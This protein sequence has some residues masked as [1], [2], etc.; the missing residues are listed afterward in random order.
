LKIIH[1]DG[2]RMCDSEK[3]VLVIALGDHPLVNSLVAPADLGREDPVFPLDVHQCLDCGLVQL[4]DIIDSH[5]IYKNVDYLFFSSDMPTLPT[6]FSEYAEDIRRRFL[7][8]GG[9]ALEIGSNDGVL[10]NHLR[11]YARVL[12]VDPSTNV[13]LRALKRGIP[14]I[15]LFFG[16]DI[17]GKIWREWGSAD[18]IMGNNCIAHLNDLHDLMRGVDGLLADSGVFV[19]EANYWGGMVKNANFSLIYH[20]HYSFFSLKVWEEFAPK[21]G[22][23][24]FDAWVTP[25]QGG[26]LRLFMSKDNRPETARLQ[27]LRREEEETRL[28]NHRTSLEYRMAVETSSAKLHDLVSGLKAQGKTVAGYGAAAKGFTILKVAGIGAEHLDYF[29]DDSPA[30]QGWFTPVDHIPIISRNEAESRLPDYFL[31]LA[32]NYAKVIVEKEESYRSNGGKFIIPYADP[33]IL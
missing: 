20:D 26:S 6:Y 1:N 18:V 25:A 3:L 7:K 33:E 23:R 22:M 19:V 11:G 29:V 13:V 12:G 9:F 24:V 4:R 5:E 16:E 15:P 28:N 27:D 14:T 17:A 21:F 30:K 10:L 31:I 2:C 8:E 32:P